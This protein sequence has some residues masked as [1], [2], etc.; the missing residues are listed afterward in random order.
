MPVRVQPT[1]AD[2]II[3]DSATRWYIDDERQLHIV[4]GAGAPVA[5]FSVNAWQSVQKKVGA[6]VFGHPDQSR[7]A[8][9]SDTAQS[10][11][12]P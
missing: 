4:D 5:A 6:L 3:F 9:D 1:D 11:T 10:D 12:R 2:A 8:S 7:G